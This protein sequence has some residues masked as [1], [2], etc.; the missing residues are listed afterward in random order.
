[1][2]PRED[3]LATKQAFRASAAIVCRDDHDRV[4]VLRTT[5]KT[6]WELPGGSVDVD[7]SPTHTVAREALEELGYP[8]LAGRLL[9]VDHVSSADGGPGGPMFHFLFDGGTIP[10]G[11]VF[12]LA[13]D[14]IVEYQ[15]ASP[16]DAIMLVGPGTRPATATCAQSGGARRYLDNGS[17]LHRHE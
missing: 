13:P 17:L 11:T 8:L 9:C 15:F 1:M 12:T 7:E 16:Q 4:L 14:E 6:N 5:Y 2:M 3:Y 10:T